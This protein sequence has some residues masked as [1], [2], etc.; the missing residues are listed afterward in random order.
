MILNDAEAR[1]YLRLKAIFD[2]DVELALFEE[3][4]DHLYN[5]QLVPVHER[6]DLEHYPEVRK[7]PVEKMERHLKCSMESLLDIVS[8][9]RAELKTA[10]NNNTH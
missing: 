7:M 3:Q 9:L 10:Q 8:K 5:T 6:E 4:L 1:E 2:A